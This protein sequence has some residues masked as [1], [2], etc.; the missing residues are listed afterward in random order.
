MPAGEAGIATRNSLSEK[1]DQRF[2][3]RRTTMSMRLIS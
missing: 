3:R 1:V 2:L